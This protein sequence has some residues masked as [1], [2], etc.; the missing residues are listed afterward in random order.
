MS[1]ILPRHLHK[2][3]QDL[4]WCPGPYATPDATPIPEAMQR[5]LARVES[6]AREARDAEYTLPDGRWL[7][8]GSAKEVAVDA[9]FHP[10]PM[11][12]RRALQEVIT[13]A[14][15]RPDYL[16][17]RTDL[18]AN[19]V[20]TG[21]SSLFPGLEGRLLYELK[22]AVGTSCPHIKLIFNPN[23]KENTR[24]AWFG[25]S[26]F[27]GMATRSSAFVTK[28]EYDEQGPLQAARKLGF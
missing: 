2:A 19:I 28:A 5:D 11:G 4:C 14:F 7:H 15:M 3:K 26:I 8:A 1:D 22:A 10:P 9:V 17:I 12:R 23:P 25:G 6:Q 27:T 18:A 20:L 21:G 13:T 16:D 24:Q